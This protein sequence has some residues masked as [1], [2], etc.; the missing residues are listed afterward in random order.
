MVGMRLGPFTA[1]T[2]I[3]II[4]ATL[5]FTAFG[6]GL[7]EILAGGQQ[8]DIASILTPTILLPFLGMAGLALLP[9]L[10]RLWRRRKAAL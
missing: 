10:W 6:T 7:A 5:V 2:A 3:G 9:V 8:P 1:A 4:P